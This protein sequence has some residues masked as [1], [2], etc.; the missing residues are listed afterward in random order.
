MLWKLLT[1]KNARESSNSDQ[2]DSDDDIEGNNKFKERKLKESSSPSPTVM[3]NV[4]GPNLSPSEVVNIAVGECQISISFTSEPNCEALVFPKDYSIARNHFLE[5]R[6]IPNTYFIHWT[7]SKEMLLK[8]H[9]ILWKGNNF[10][11]KSV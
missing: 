5:E 3:Y 7:G 9:F 10:K 4:D 11:V 6:E 2:T 1:D 8:A